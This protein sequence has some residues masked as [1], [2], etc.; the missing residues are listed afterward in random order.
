MWLLPY[1]IHW[2]VLWVI[3][4][5]PDLSFLM[6]LRRKSSGSQNLNFDVPTKTHRRRSSAQIDDTEKKHNFRTVVSW[7]TT[8]YNGAGGYQ[9][10]GTTRRLSP[11]PPPS[12]RSVQSAQSWPSYLKSNATRWTSSPPTRRWYLLGTRQMRMRKNF[13]VNDEVLLPT[14]LAFPQ[15]TRSLPATRNAWCFRS[16]CS[17]RTSCRF[18]QQQSSP[19]CSQHPPHSPR[20]HRGDRFLVGLRYKSVYATF[21]I[22]S[23]KLCAV[24]SLSIIWRFT[25]HQ[26]DIKDR[27]RL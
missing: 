22:L 8:S 26:S 11:P 2:F 5:R 19:P 20:P 6:N 13:A 16:V 18:H 15:R 25:A 12:R 4:N 17:T 3:K 27:R 9:R 23:C 7:D 14:L 1:L 21:I 24:S 10:F